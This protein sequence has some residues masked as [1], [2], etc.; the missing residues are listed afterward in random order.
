ML[1]T[2]LGQFLSDKVIEI[3]LNAKNLKLLSDN[4]IFINDV[5][6]TQD[7]GGPII[8]KIILNGF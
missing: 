7:F 2:D 5:D 1:K 8:K 6:F 3:L 4:N